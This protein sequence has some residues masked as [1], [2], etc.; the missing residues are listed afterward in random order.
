MSFLFSGLSL[1]LFDGFAFPTSCHFTIIVP[2]Q[3]DEREK[4]LVFGIKQE[5][6]TTDRR[7]GQGERFFVQDQMFL[8][9]MHRRKTIHFVLSVVIMPV[10]AR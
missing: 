1:L 4:H 10:L 5:R 6:H 7:L 8:I 3:F 2:G 9:I